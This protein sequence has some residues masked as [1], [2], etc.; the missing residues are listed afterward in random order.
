MYNYLTPSLLVPSFLRNIYFFP[1]PPSLPPSLSPLPSFSLPTALSSSCQILFILLSTLSSSFHP[2][3]RGR[4]KAD[5]QAH[6]HA[7]GTQVLICVSKAI[8]G[9]NK[10]VFDFPI[11]RG[12]TLQTFDTKTCVMFPR[13]QFRVGCSPR[14]CIA[15]RQSPPRRTA[16]AVCLD[17]EN[18]F[19]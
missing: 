6:R 2:V 7:A 4:T 17:R 12:V 18:R 11:L 1:L 13:V 9:R 3:A 8:R 15:S 5:I 16:A 14:N 10:Y 19:S